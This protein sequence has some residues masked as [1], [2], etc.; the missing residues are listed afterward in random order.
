M[1]MADI[2][3]SDT[4]NENMVGNVIGSRKNIA[5]KQTKKRE[6]IT[7]IRSK[8]DDCCNNRRA[9]IDVFRKTADSIQSLLHPPKRIPYQMVRIQN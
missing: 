4:L 6:P 2:R 8:I 9:T 1:R 5:S 3:P 7:D